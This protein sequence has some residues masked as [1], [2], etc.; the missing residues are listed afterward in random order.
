MCPN[1]KF[2][3]QRGFSMLELM[4]AMA[5]MTVITAAAF[6]L[7]GGSLRFVNA[8]YHMTDAEENLRTAHEMINRDLTEV[9]DGLRGIGMIQVPVGFVSN[10]L[11]QSPVLCPSSTNVCMALVQSDDNVPGT[12]AVPQTSPVVNV[13][14]KSDR[15]T[16]LTRDT[17]T[18]TPV[19]L[20]A[21]KITVVGSNTNIAV[22]AAD[23]LSHSF[24]VGEIYAIVAQN[25]IAFGVITS[26]NTTTNTLVMA[27]GDLYGLNQ[28]SSTSPIYAVAGLAAGASTAASII[29]LQIIHYYVNANNL[30]I[31]RVFG[32]KGKGFVD[33]IVAEHVTNLQFRY[34]LNLTDANGF[35]PQPRG[36]LTSS[37]E[38]AAV[39]QVETTVG[40]ETVRA[41][42]AVTANNNGRQTISVTTATTVR[43]LQFRQAL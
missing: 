14:D 36:Q 18:F 23:M 27:N 34:L 42:N 9:G 43:N 29:R 19:S 25:S 12:T 28:N 41:V 8:T 16:L 7:M 1:R 10:Y 38:Q 15:V 2:N 22:T 17:N 11:T 20:A 6:A 37:T 35:V 4:V 39:R 5:T 32:V 26:I 24:Q 30:L 3:Q 40:V 33:A 13:L 31:R 21:G